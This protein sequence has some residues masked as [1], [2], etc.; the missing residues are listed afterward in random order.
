MPYTSL[1]LIISCGGSGESVPS[2]S[3]EGDGG[4]GTE[5]EEEEDEPEEG[6]EPSGCRLESS[7]TPPEPIL[8]LWFMG[9]S[10]CAVALFFPATWVS[11]FISIFL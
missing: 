1:V 10:F 7:L 3:S 9:S 6:D 5:E 8:F 4:R 2:S 11:D